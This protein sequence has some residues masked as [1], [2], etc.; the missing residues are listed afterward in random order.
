MAIEQSFQVVP[1]SSADKES[2]ND[3][4]EIIQRNLDALYGAAHTHGVR[5]SAPDSQDGEQNDIVIVNLEGTYYLYVKVS[6]TQWARTASL[7]LI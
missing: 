4:T 5:T 2:L 6:N 3:Y 7:T 1:P